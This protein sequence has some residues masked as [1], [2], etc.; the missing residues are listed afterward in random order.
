MYSETYLDKVE[1][2]KQRLEKVNY[3][4]DNEVEVESSLPTRMELHHSKKRKKKKKANFPLLKVLL[5]FFILLP[6]STI[7]AYT[8]FSG[9]QTLKADSPNSGGEEVL[10]ETDSGDSTQNSEPTKSTE[11]ISNE[12][13]IT[14]DQA[15]DSNTITSTEGTT[16]PQNAI[17]N[18]DQVNQEQKSSDSMEQVNNEQTNEN[19]NI[20]IINHVVQPKETLFSIAMK[21]YHSKDGIEKIINQN[22]IINNEIQA[23]QTLQI[24]LSK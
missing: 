24:P 16:A 8:Y 10:F 9:H 12:T 2:K 21:Y 3:I 15:S 7:L 4:D 14:D 1:K 19:S 23:G 22:H 17:N 13:S 5:T 20:Q 18:A 6:I 11:N